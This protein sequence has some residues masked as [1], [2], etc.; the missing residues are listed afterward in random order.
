MRI[1]TSNFPGDPLGNWYEEYHKLIHYQI[2]KRLSKCSEEEIEDLT[3]EVFRRAARRLRNGGEPIANPKKYLLATADSVF[4]DYGRA[5]TGKLEIVSSQYVTAE[6]E[7]RSY[8]DDVEC[9]DDDRPEI[10]AE[11]H[12]LWEEALRYLYELPPDQREAIKLRYIEEWDLKQ[13]ARAMGKS[14]STVQNN[15][16]KGIGQLRIRW[17]REDF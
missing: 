8:F 2:K 12:A 4:A 11:K 9:S 14:R 13:I 6:G 16:R 15:I 7:E 17:L 10:V 1:N 3:S 5:N